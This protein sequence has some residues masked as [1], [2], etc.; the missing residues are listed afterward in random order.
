MVGKY[1]KN[2]EEYI[3]VTS[4]LELMMPF[5][6]DSFE[7]SMR[8]QGIDPHWVMERSQ[9]VGSMIHSWIEN[10]FLGMKVLDIKP[11]DEQERMYRESVD[12]FLALEL[13]NFKSAEKRVSN[14]EFRFMGTLDAI[15]DN[16]IT[17]FKVWNCWNG[18]M[19][20][21]STLKAKL[22]KVQMQLSLYNYACGC[23][24]KQAVV[25]FRPDNKWEWIDLEYTD[26]PI[27]WLRDNRE[28]V[29][30]KMLEESELVDL[31]Y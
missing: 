20:A 24:Y 29:R 1:K 18:K 3:R 11:K 30:E 16:T 22:K 10:A 28:K 19:P 12:G 27:K 23:Q 25:F 13:A 9:R 4:I 31:D 7:T 26:K 6:K 8:T 5:H 2:G 15:V 17:D 21:P 14:R